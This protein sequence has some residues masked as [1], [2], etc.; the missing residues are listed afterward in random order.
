MRDRTR[1]DLDDCIGGQLALA[2]AL[3][4]PSASSA[5]V[6]RVG[7]AIHRVAPLPRLFGELSGFPRGFSPCRYHRGPTDRSLINR[8]KNDNERRIISA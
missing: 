1:L 4:A 8:E 7:T 5:V 6:P 3:G 2:F